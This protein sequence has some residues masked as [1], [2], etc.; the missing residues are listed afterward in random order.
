MAS[1]PAASFVAPR[2]H[3]TLA[4]HQRKKDKEEPSPCLS[5]PHLGQS[6]NHF[7][8]ALATYFVK[9]GQ[10]F[11]QSIR[12]N[13]DGS[14]SCFALPVDNLSSVCA[15]SVV[16]HSDKFDPTKLTQAELKPVPSQSS[17]GVGPRKG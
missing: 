7:T 2:V 17:P 6:S 11:S 1:I 4:L 12:T 16:I 14:T 15:P 3:E 10:M 8:P 5:N 9:N 13:P